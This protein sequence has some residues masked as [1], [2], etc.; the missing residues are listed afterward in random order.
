MALPVSCSAWSQRLSPPN[1]QRLWDG[2]GPFLRPVS[3]V[4]SQGIG[5]WLLLTHF[6]KSRLPGPLLAGT[7]T[8][9]LGFAWPVASTLG[10]HPGP[11]ALLDSGSEA[12]VPDA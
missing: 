6:L 10:Q 3:R 2:R 5:P 4:T 12:L 8:C 11:P 9:L 1:C 7:G